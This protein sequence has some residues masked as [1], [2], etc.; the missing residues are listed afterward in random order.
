MS[1]L[2]LMRWL[3]GAP[4]RYD[5]GMCWLTLGRDA[6]VR[7][8]L[9]RAV[10]P[11]DAVLEIGCGTG[12]LTE[13]LVARGARVAAVD[14]SPEMLDRARA[15]LSRRSADAQ[16]ET[17][18]TGSVT[19]SEHTAAEI[20]GL[21]AARFDACVAAFALSEMSAAERRYVLE[22]MRE[23]LRPGGVLAVGDEGVPR[24]PAAR[25]L[26]AALRAPQAVLAWLLAGSVSRPLRRLPEEIARAGFGELS[27]Q[28]FLLGTLVAVVARRPS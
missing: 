17:D 11:G 8:A 15:R 16:G 18:A 6:R 27:E 5:A 4:G 20:D 28:R 9:A 25:A 12:A 3:E 10:R 19:W 1:S 21:P 14:Q 23:R 7:E 24:R 22:A 26:A 2:A 13:R